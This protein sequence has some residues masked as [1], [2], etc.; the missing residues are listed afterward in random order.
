MSNP[1][2]SRWLLVLAALGATA[3]CARITDGGAYVPSERD[4]RF[5]AERYASP[6]PDARTLADMEALAAGWNK[7]PEETDAAAAT[8]VATK[9][10]RPRTR[11]AAIPPSQIQQPPGP[12]A[13]AAST[14]APRRSLW[15]KQ[16][17]EVDL[18]SVVRGICRGC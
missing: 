5:V 10:E 13:G 2:R 7:M 1:Y 17:W 11:T 9:R 18:D 4:P 12:S 3:G 16:P 14:L 6:Q 15:E 8:A